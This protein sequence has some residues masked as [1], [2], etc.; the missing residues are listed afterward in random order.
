[1]ISIGLA[2]AAGF[3][4]RIVQVVVEASLYLLIGFLTAAALRILVGPERVRRL[5]GSG[6]VAAP[7]RAWLAAS[8]LLPVCSLGV[9]PVL[10]EFRRAGVP[11]HAALTFALA[12]PMLNPISLLGGISYLGPG[13]LAVLI[14]G[15]SAVS[16]GAGLILGPGPEG[17]NPGEADGPIAGPGSRK[18]AAGLVLAA[19]TATGSAWGDIGV[20]LLGAGAVAAVVTPSYLAGSMFAGDP[21]AIPR[22]AAFAPLTYATPDKAVA[23]IPEMIK[24]RQS[25]GALFLLMSL[26]AGMTLGHARWAARSY[27]PKAAATWLAVAFGLALGVALAVDRATPAVGTANVDNDHF[28]EFA[29]PFAEAGLADFGPVLARFV[30]GVE[31]ARRATVGALGVLILA[32]LALR[33]AGERGRHEAYLIPRAPAAGLARS[34]ER[35][36]PP[37]VVRVAGGF[38]LAAIAG[39]GLY[40]FF[41]APSETF[42]D[43]GIIKADFYGELGEPTLDAARHHLGLWE[44]QVEKLRVGSMIRF[45]PSGGEALRRTEELRSA[46]RSLRAS[47]DSGRR[48]EARS[49]SFRVARIQERCRQAYAMP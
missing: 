36:V 35:P 22:M 42:R 39:V 44:R 41:P 14:L 5:F 37:G 25:A 3:A 18:L 8:A 30:A 4:L 28:N 47:I 24:F 49:L 26:G 40:A 34:W 43:L 31:P 17:A 6:R 7:F 10:R 32:G 12:A 2:L 9:L 11:R 20:G 33:L 38:G 13:L 15:T 46:L 29:N 27:G 16:I 1:M 21:W 45:G 19:R 48:D 23:T